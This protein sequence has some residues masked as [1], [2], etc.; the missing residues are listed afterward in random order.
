MADDDLDD[1]SDDDFDDLPANALD[2]LEASA[3]RATQQPQQQPS[4]GPEGPQQLGQP[5]S[6]GSTPAPS[7]SQPPSGVPMQ[8]GLQQ[9]AAQL[10]RLVNDGQMSAQEAR[11]RFAQAQQ[12]AAA[13]VESDR[14]PRC[15]TPGFPHKKPYGLR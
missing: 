10:S 6:S 13:E 1:F 7:A 8:Q 2:D 3:I 11:D 4:Q 9:L 14:H 15:P 5:G 12:R